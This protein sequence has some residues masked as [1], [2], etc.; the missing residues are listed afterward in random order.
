VGFC[1][2]NAVQ[3][4]KSLAGLKNNVLGEKTTVRQHLEKKRNITTLR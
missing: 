1:A 2:Q 3:L 4:N